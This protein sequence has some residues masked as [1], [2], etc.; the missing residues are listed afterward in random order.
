MPISEK[1]K[2]RTHSLG[3]ST[4][5]GLFWGYGQLQGGSWKGTYYVV[6][7]EQLDTASHIRQ[8]HPKEFKAAEVVVTDKQKEGAWRY[9]LYD[10]DLS[11][12]QKPADQTKKQRLKR[13]DEFR[14]KEQ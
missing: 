12:P 5:P 14:K 13:A 7:W 2:S 4:L 9:P 6:D 1:D 11:Q 10:G 8:V 3:R